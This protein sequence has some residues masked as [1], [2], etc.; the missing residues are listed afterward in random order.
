VGFAWGP[1]CVTWYF[2]VKVENNEYHELFAGKKIEKREF[3]GSI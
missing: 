2:L 3:F 1:S